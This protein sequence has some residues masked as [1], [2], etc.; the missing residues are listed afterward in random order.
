MSLVTQ[1]K[2]S[3]KAQNGRE[4]LPLVAASPT[5]AQE[6]KVI[7]ASLEKNETKLLAKNEGHLLSSTLNWVNER[8]YLFGSAA[9]VLSFCPQVALA[10]IVVGAAFSALRYFANK[11]DKVENKNNLISTIVD[12]ALAVGVIASLISSSTFVAIP[13]LVVFSGVAIFSVYSNLKNSR[14]WN[15]TLDILSLGLIAFSGRLMYQRGDFSK[16]GTQ[17]SSLFKPKTNLAAD[18]VGETLAFD[19]K[20]ASLANDPLGNLPFKGSGLDSGPGPN[21]SSGFGILTK[22]LVTP[23]QTIST[24][25][26]SNIVV[27]AKV[28]QAAYLLQMS[29]Y[30]QNK[31]I[32][33]DERNEEVQ[34]TSSPEEIVFPLSTESPEIEFKSEHLKQAATLEIER[35]QGSH[36]E[37]MNKA[38][39]PVLYPE[40]PSL[41]ND[42]INYTGFRN[43]NEISLPHKEGLRDKDL[44]FKIDSKN[45][46]VEVPLSIGQQESNEKKSKNT[47]TS[48]SLPS[49]NEE[50]EKL[51]KQIDNAQSLEK[52]DLIKLAIIRSLGHFELTKDS[53]YLIIIAQKIENMPD[54][55]RADMYW[56]CE[57]SEMIKD[58]FINMIKVELAA[59]DMADPEVARAIL[60]IFNVVY[61]NEPAVLTNEEAL[62]VKQ[63][64]EN[65]YNGFCGNEHSDLT[66]LE[67]HEKIEVLAAFFKAVGSVNEIAKFLRED[68]EVKDRTT[69]LN[70]IA[71]FSIR[72]VVRGS[73]E[74]ARA[75]MK[76]MGFYLTYN[77]YETDGIRLKIF[78]DSV[79]RKQKVPPHTELESEL[80]Y[81]AI[82]L[83]AR[84]PEVTIED[85]DD[86]IAELITEEIIDPERYQ[87][88][89]SKLNSFV[90]FLA[91]NRNLSW[92]EFFNLITRANEKL[93]KFEKVDFE[94]L[95]ADARYKY[96]NQMEERLQKCFDKI[97]GLSSEPLIK[98]EEKKLMALICKALDLK[99][100]ERSLNLP[101]EGGEFDGALL[102]DPSEMQVG[103]PSLETDGIKSFLTLVSLDP[104]AKKI[105]IEAFKNASSKEQQLIL[106]TIKILLQDTNGTREFSTELPQQLMNI[107]DLKK[108]KELNRIVEDVIF[109]TAEV[110]VAGIS[111]KTKESLTIQEL[112][113]YR[114]KINKLMNLHTQTRPIDSERDLVFEEKLAFKLIQAFYNLSK[115]VLNGSFRNED[116]VEQSSFRKYL[117]VMN[118][119]LNHIYRYDSKW[120]DLLEE[121]PSWKVSLGIVLENY[122]ATADP[123]LSSFPA[124]LRNVFVFDKNLCLD[125]FFDS[126]YKAADN[127][128]LSAEFIQSRIKAVGIMLCYNN[129]DKELYRERAKPF[130]S[131]LIKLWEREHEEDKIATLKEYIE[132][133][134]GEDF[135]KEIESSP[136]E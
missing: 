126:L 61:S 113:Y 83:E 27:Q 69:F 121:Y 7:L 67:I 3:T 53:F 2:E 47:E 98:I 89:Q 51:L 80:L 71:D 114:V 132:T 14:N 4:T 95:V 84:S 103:L 133:E 123:L 79:K 28:P 112:E 42:Q 90:L 131:K 15:A 72:L 55:Y 77:N 8:K 22:S 48:M 52:H 86:F 38:R 60:Q 46:E 32:K 62:I 81:D 125:L 124:L 75:L 39:N 49:E 76:A 5:S 102:D 119:I 1:K 120:K 35:P 10:G 85:E 18:L 30:Q 107:F 104:N 40:L 109:E 99:G 129:R 16:F 122:F 58:V 33:F 136:D 88:N 29:S 115:M 17:I 82:V 44:R 43:N 93:F 134:F 11:L 24:I 96:L 34:S 37:Q 108:S 94:D 97:S 64:I 23:K 19:T 45:K 74:E 9:I 105:C 118:A 50:I 66:M 6:L 13:A 127:V 91:N 135:L 92:Q 36:F 110:V 128:D 54:A 41:G 31:A 73:P 65:T 116:D 106:E 63:Y 21:G 12:G 56:Q 117:L 111:P 78:N 26:S 68:D 70:L 57:V 130:F 59:G 20:P 25:P 101:H 100:C 87:E